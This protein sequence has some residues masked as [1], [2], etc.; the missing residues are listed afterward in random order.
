MSFHLRTTTKVDSPRDFKNIA[1]DLKKL[2]KQ[3]PHIY[4]DIRVASCK[5]T[6]AK[7]T[8]RY[9]DRMSTT[10]HIRNEQLE[11]VI[12]ALK[13]SNPNY[14]L[15]DVHVGLEG[16]LDDY[17][18]KVAT[19]AQTMVTTVKQYSVGLFDLFVKKLRLTNKIDLSKFVG[20]NASMRLVVIKYDEYCAI[21]NPIA[22]KSALVVKDV[23]D[24]NASLGRVRKALQTDNDEA[25]KK[26]M[27]ELTKKIHEGFLISFLKDSGL[28][29]F[30]FGMSPGNGE[31]GLNKVVTTDK[32]N[33]LEQPY[34][35]SEAGWNDVEQLKSALII[36]RADD[37]SKNI[38]QMYKLSMNLMDETRRISTDFCVKDPYTCAA[39]VKYASL[40]SQMINIYTKA[41]DMCWTTCLRVSQAGIIEQK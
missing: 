6:M 15:H 31:Q 11:N 2:D 18:K 41:F 26:A 19:F 29:E 35:L 23:A 16:I 3:L 37:V 32:F 1:A 34:V 24:W 40:V 36:Q 30:E 28:A 25:L 12:A 13:A 7:S 21:G 20:I 9:I 14:T 10:E 39:L 4:T 17:A 22:D 5:C 38:N 8:M 33:H 27:S